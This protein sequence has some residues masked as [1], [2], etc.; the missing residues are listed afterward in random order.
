VRD[1]AALYTSQILPEPMISAAP[2]RAGSTRLLSARMLTLAPDGQLMPPSGAAAAAAAAFGHSSSAAV[3]AAWALPEAA[4]APCHTAA[5]AAAG[6]AAAAGSADGT[7]GSGD[8]SI[9]VLAAV[10]EMNSGSQGSSDQADQASNNNSVASI[11][12]SS[13]VTNQPLQLQRLAAAVQELDVAGDFRE[14]VSCTPNDA[15]AAAANAAAGEVVPDAS[16]I[17][18]D[19]AAA[20]AATVTPAAASLVTPE[21]SLGAWG[22]HHSGLAP[23]PTSDSNWGT[24]NW[25]TM[26]ECRPGNS[27]D[28]LASNLFSTQCAV[29]PTM[30]DCVYEHTIA[31]VPNFGERAAP[32]SS[33][34]FSIVNFALLALLF[35]ASFF[36]VYNGGISLSVE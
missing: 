15:A 9:D 4:V 8:N 6:A 27:G 1:A 29:I 20:A 36:E 30:P 25:G 12:I 10:I 22:L 17:A 26:M 16:D 23:A 13:E 35:A 11:A 14:F 5:G 7:D 21:A 3:P 24:G 19:S 2:G 34:M 28:T 33:W 32:Q 31:A 18:A